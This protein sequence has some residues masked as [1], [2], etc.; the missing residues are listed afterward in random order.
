MN[1][2]FPSQLGVR[3]RSS[4]SLASNNYRSAGLV[5][6]DDAW[7]TPG[8]ETAAN[9]ADLSVSTSVGSLTLNPAGGC[10]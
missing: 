3:L 5:R 4:D 1:L 8:Y 9:R 7:Q 6:V 10:K 2:C